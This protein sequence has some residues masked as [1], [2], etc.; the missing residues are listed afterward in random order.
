MNSKKIVFI[1]SIFTSAGI[2]IYWSL[3]FIGLFPVEEIIPGY[4][5][6]FLS[7]P[8]A[9]LWIAIN[10]ILLAIYIKKENV[11][12]SAVFGLLTASGMIFLGLYALLYGINT[13][14][15]F[16]LTADELIEI[17]IKIYCLS[18][19]SYFIIHFSKELNKIS[20]KVE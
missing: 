13:G 9:D 18:V 19:G 17:L 10:S 8:I 2:I 20:E 15:I 11:K 14:L 7:F 5:N 3:V 6:W 12:K 1:F 4:K 16:K